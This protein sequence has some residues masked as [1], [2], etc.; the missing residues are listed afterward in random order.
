M[1]NARER[2]MCRNGMNSA[3]GFSFIELLVVI[4]IIFIVSAMAL[5]QLLPTWRQS[6]SNAA[7]DQVKSTLRQARETAVAQR[8]TIAVQFTGNNTISLYQFVVVG[9]TSTIA[10]APFL[11][12]PIQANVSFTT[13]GGMPDTPDA[14]GLPGVGGGI[15]FGSVSGGPPSGMDFQSD[16]TFTDGTGIPINGTI[17]MGVANIPASAR[18]VTV[19][20]NTGRIRGYHGTGTGWFQQ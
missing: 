1:N 6:Q 20:G 11:T 4:G 12:I 5:F 2:S 17:F 15:M 13:F 8:R 10:A 3:W 16:G 14:Y 7:L 9:A 19:L 18:A